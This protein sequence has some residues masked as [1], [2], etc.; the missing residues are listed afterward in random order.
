MVDPGARGRT[1]V[2]GEAYFTDR[3]RV[4]GWMGW[5]P[6]DGEG[7]WKRGRVWVA[8]SSVERRSG[9]WM[10]TQRLHSVTR[11]N[12][13]LNFEPMHTLKPDSTMVY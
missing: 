9:A 12:N 3:G 6:I 5:G 8:L 7:A 2:H 4:E 10:G 13:R 1:L 11:Y